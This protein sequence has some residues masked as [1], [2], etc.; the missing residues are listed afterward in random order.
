MAM[1]IKQLF[2]SD[3]INI[4]LQYSGNKVIIRLQDYFPDSLKYITIDEN[5]LKLINGDNY[6]YIRKLNCSD[7]DITDVAP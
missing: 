3:I 4:I 5:E 2:P 6:Q 7:S 1:S